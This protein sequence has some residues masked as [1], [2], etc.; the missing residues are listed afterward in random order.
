MPRLATILILVV[1]YSLDHISG[2][3]QMR[4][5][6]SSDPRYEPFDLQSEET[7]EAV[8][9]SVAAIAPRLE[10]MGFQNRGH[11]QSFEGRAQRRGLR[12]I[13]RE[14]SIASICQALHG[15]RRIESSS[16]D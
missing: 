1:V 13:V 3:S 2:F 10:S 15:G 12:H 5:W 11:F 16:K 8:T 4:Q 14:S 9:G 6:S 7:P